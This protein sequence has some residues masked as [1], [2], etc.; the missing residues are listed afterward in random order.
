VHTAE[1]REAVAGRD[2]RRIV[3]IRLCSAALARP[4]IQRCLLELGGL[5]KQHI[6]VIK[7]EL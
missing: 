6:G 5:F 7:D 1:W 2:G 3:E 4:Y